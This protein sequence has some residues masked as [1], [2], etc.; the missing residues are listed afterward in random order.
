MS[1]RDLISAIYTIPKQ[2][3]DYNG[4]MSMIYYPILFDKLVY[5]IFDN[6]NIGDSYVRHNNKSIFTLE[7]HI[8]FLKELH[9]DDRVYAK[10]YYVNHD[11]KKL[12]YAQEL[13]HVDG[14][15]AATFEVLAIHV[16]LATRKSVEF[17]PNTLAALNEL[18]SEA[19][20]APPPDFVGRSIRLTGKSA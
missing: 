2:W 5:E 4:H 1:G 8:R 13:Y 16:D 15:L 11:K 7:T 9:L 3:L 10:F 20:K 18:E 12:V 19:R 6:I 17:P 14:W